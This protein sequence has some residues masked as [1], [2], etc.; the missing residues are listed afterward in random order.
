MSFQVVC[1]RTYARVCVCVCACVCMGESG[2][3]SES[4]DAEHFCDSPLPET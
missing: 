3:L 2:S 4:D 1:V